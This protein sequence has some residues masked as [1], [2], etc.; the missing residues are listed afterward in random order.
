MQRNDIAALGTAVDNGDLWIDGV[1]VA[2]GAHEQCALRYEQLADQVD[3]Q[4]Q[5]LAAATTLPGFG[6]F[7]SGDALRRGFE[8]KATDAIARLREYAAAARSLAHTFRA[9]AAAY[10]DADDAVA[11]ATRKVAADA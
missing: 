3:I 11:A 10:R 5:Q 4:I 8:G 2:E 6:G 7:A 1:L 9:A